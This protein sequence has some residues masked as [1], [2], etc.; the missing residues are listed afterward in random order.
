MNELLEVIPRFTGRRVLVI[1][2]LCLDEYIVGRARRLSREAPVPVLEFEDQ[3]TLPGAATNPALNIQALGGQALMVGV[4]GEDQAGRVLRRELEELGI[5][6]QG[7]IVSNP[8]RTTVKTRVVAEASLIFP[9]QVV[10][11]DRQDSSSLDSSLLEQLTGCIRSAAPEADAILLSD[12]K[13]GVVCPDVIRAA[14]D[15]AGGRIITVDSQGDLFKFKGFTL[16]KSNVQEAEAVLGR[17]LADAASLR[18]AGRG[19]V[20]RLAAG[21]V[22][23]T[24]GGEGMSLFE[25]GGSDL[26]LPAANRSE[27]FDV[28]GAGDTVIATATLALCAGAS[29]PQAVTLANHAAGLVVR[30]LGNAT[31]T[32]EELGNS[33]LRLNREGVHP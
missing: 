2:D 9:Q 27:V 28:T 30:K 21:A 25:K 12:Y 11:V 7:V 4:V 17:P 5:G 8:R 19:L 6:V 33:I 22:L 31:T 14:M 1:G 26:H 3:F 15:V 32:Q 13:G 24:R 16:V 10:R 20:K 18:R 29:M 23:I